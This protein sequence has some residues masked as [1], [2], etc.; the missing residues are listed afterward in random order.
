MIEMEENLL[1]AVYNNAVR[2]IDIN[3]EG[4]ESRDFEPISM[5]QVVELAAILYEGTSRIDDRMRDLLV[6]YVVARMHNQLMIKPW[7]VD[8]M[9]VL[10]D[11]GLHD[12]LY[13]VLVQIPRV[14]N[15]G[16]PFKRHWR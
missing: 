1:D 13:E 10:L 16:M 2:A 14:C 12:F 8:D 11:S 5:E 6:R 3:A 9:R 15:S 4:S 7:K